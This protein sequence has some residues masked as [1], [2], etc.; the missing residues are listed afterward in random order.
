ME[1]QFKMEVIAKVNNGQHV[2]TRRK[3][4]R[5]AEKMKTRRTRLK[6]LGGKMLDLVIV[7]VLYGK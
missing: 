7:K 6:Q 4:E 3:K 5:D 1:S 2:E